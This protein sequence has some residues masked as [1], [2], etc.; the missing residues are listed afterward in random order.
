ML[1]RAA[2]VQAAL[3]ELQTDVDGR[4][5]AAQGV[6]ADSAVLPAIIANMLETSDIG[7]SVQAYDVDTAK[8]DVAQTYTATQVP[9]NGTGSVSR[10]ESVV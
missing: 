9:D 3:N 5:P 4:A 6:L 8:L 7:V 10:S 2:N 1:T